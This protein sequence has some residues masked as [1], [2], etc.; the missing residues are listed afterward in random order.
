MIVRLAVEQGRG[1]SPHRRHRVVEQNVGNVMGV[2]SVHEAD[3]AGVVGVRGKM[4]PIRLMQPVRRI[5]GAGNVVIE[6]VRNKKIHSPSTDGIRGLSKALHVQIRITSL[7]A[8]VFAGE[9][10][11]FE[12][13]DRLSDLE[14]ERLAPEI[15]ER[16]YTDRIQAAF[17]SE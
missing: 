9:T 6:G 5:I 4:R 12:I 15:S 8:L 10:T 2:L 14:I 3:T 13:R 16:I 11:A 1:I 7:L 17:K